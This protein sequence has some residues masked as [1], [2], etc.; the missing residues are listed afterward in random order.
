MFCFLRELAIIVTLTICGATVSLYSGL[1]PPPWKEPE[2]AA[3]EISIQDAQG[4]AVIWIDA[5]KRTDYDSGHIP[6]AIL[7]NDSNWEEGIQNLMDSWLIHTRPIVVYCS[8]EQCN[9]SKRIA[10]RLRESLP[11]AEIYTL[12]GGWESW[13]K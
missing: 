8:S 10:A 13:E 2:L 5:R 7:L 6:D 9:S 12:K 11:E 4:L 3:G 1:M